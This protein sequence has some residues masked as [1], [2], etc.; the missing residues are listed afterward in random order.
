MVLRAQEPPIFSV[1]M[2]LVFWLTKRLSWKEGLSTLIVFLIGHHLSM[3]TLSTGHHMYSAAWRV[4]NRLWNSES[5][6]TSVI[7]QGCR[8]RCNSCW[9]LQSRRNSSCK[10]DDRVISHCVKKRSHLSKNSRMRQLSTYSNGKGILSCVIII[11]ASLYCQLL[12]SSLQEF[13]LVDWINTLNR[14]GFYQKASVD[15]ERTEEQLT[16]SSK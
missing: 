4:P 15:S 14:Q 7:W 2:K 13:Y 8:I 1:Q 16:W 12:G 11:V 6:K 3:M 10:E 5:N 9:D